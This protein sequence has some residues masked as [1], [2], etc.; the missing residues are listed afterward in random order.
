LLIRHSK[1]SANIVQNT[2]LQTAFSAILLT[3]YDLRSADTS[4][5][6][7]IEFSNVRGYKNLKLTR[8]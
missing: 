8:L 1:Y 7:Y 5:Q 3:G 6:S 4:L 2:L